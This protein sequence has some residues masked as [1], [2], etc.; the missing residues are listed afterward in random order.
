MN[1]QNKIYVGFAKQIDFAN[2]GN[3]IKISLNESDIAKLQDNLTD[4]KIRLAL[5]KR[6][7]ADKWGNTHSLEIDTWKPTTPKSQP[8]LP[9]QQTEERFTENNNNDG[10][11]I[12]F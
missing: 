12:P 7:E 4:G 10:E 1:Q 6:K 3:I 5:M 11:D 8:A 9:V 2:G